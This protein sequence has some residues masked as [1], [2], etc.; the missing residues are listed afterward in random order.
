VSSKK[1]ASTVLS[2]FILLSP[3]AGLAQS[4]QTNVVANVRA[5]EVVPFDGVL[6]SHDVVADM[7]VELEHAQ[8][9]CYIE[10]EGQRQIT[11]I[12]YEHRLKQCEFLKKIETDRQAKL[13]EVKQQRIDFLERRWKPIPWYEAP[14]FWYTTGVASGIVLTAGV[15]YLFFSMNN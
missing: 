11:V 4:S 5:G 2:L 9:T 3:V 6:M 7:V 8:E 10:M 1:I 14:T 13:I 15:A 12:E